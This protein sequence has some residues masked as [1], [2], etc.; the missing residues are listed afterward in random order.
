MS[1]SAL[2]FITEEDG[3]CRQ[4]VNGVV[5]SLNKKTPIPSPIGTLDII[6]FWERDM[7]RWAQVRNF[8]L[9]L[10]FP[11]DGALIL[12]N[13]YYKFNIDRKLFLLIKRRVCEVDPVYYRDYYKQLYKGELDFSTFD[14]QQGDSKVE[15]NIQE[16]GLS[17]LIKAQENT[18]YFIPF[19]SDA[20]NVLMD[21]II[22]K[23]NIL[24]S[25]PDISLS[26][27]RQY[28]PPL[29]LISSEILSASQVALFSQDFEEYFGGPTYNFSL[30]TNYFF[31]TKI[32][33]TIRV[34]GTINITFGTAGFFWIVGALNTAIV[35]G[36]TGSPGVYYSS[37]ALA[38]GN[39]VV[40]IDETFIVPA[41][42]KLYFHVSKALTGNDSF[43]LTELRIL[44]DYTF[45]ETV[46]KGFKIFDAFKKLVGKITGDEDD[47]TSTIL[48]DSTLVLTS[49][50]GI[51]GIEGAG[52]TTTFN[53][54][55]KATDVCLFTGV[56]IKD[57]VELEGRDNYFV[58]DS[59]DPA[60][61]LGDS[62]D[63][64][65]S[66]AI[67]LIHSSI[68]IG[69]KEQTS[70]DVNDVNAKSDFNGY[71][72]YTTPVKR[73]NTELDLQ[74]PYKA[75]PFEIEVLRIN[76][77][78]KTTSGGQTDNDVFVLDVA[79]G[80]NP[81]QNVLLSF[82]AS[83][84]YIVFP[85]L[86]KI[87]VGAV[88][89]ILGTANNNTTYT[90]SAVDDLS[91]TQT[92]HTDITITISEPGVSAQVTFIS[93]QV[94]QLDRS[95]I[96]DS[97]VPDVST[98][99]NVRLRPSA[100]FDKHKRW[101]VS[102]LSGYESGNIEFQSAN[103][104]SELIVAGLIDGRNRPI[105][106]L[107]NKIFLPHYLEFTTKVPISLQDTL[108]TSPNKC[109]A[110]DWENLRL[111]GFLWK[112]GLAPNSRQVQVYKTLLTVENDPKDLIS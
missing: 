65:V 50:D 52:I 37:G 59:T 17:K 106:T 42:E 70:N 84:N 43:G 30:S 27:V 60:I 112:A 63:L 55:C 8:S 62:R 98:V 9:P 12:R 86:P 25:M 72:I 45:P 47:A 34:I 102:F 7:A 97:G 105:S 87:I 57:T 22:L 36:P 79:T 2:Y 107:G 58:Q 99:F 48:Q 31:T 15:I 109:F 64:K 14:D 33:K 71:H 38:I 67:D 96:P 75:G 44:Y 26:A 54:I 68:K 88:F 66:P 76:L 111:I 73:T 74:S 82:I 5:T 51:R 81:V 56:Q 3:R 53:E 4:V 95:V 1:K 11:L 69:W 20:I 110:N 80:A 78:G 24:F 23:N 21:G 77:D 49:G 40:S 13:D 29:T 39:H 93:G 91:T 41:G 108:E 90:V 32:Q 28:F 6:I 85:P 61:E 101:F 92:V 46:I 18:K 89:S 16:G 19:D 103:R 83:G 104:N 94:Y 35:P 10:G 100:L